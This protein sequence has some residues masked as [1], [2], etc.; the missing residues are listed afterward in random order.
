MTSWTIVVPIKGLARAKTR[1]W[2]LGTPTR[3]TL[4]R[5]FARDTLAAALAAETVGRVIAVG[6]AE[7]L[8]DLDSRV[9]IVRESESGLDAAIALGVTH[10]RT[11]SLEPVAVMLGDLPALEAPHLMSALRSAEE[12]P[13]AFVADVHGTGTTLVTANAGQRFEHCFGPYS[14]RRH[15]AARFADLVATSPASIRPELRTDA[16]TL[17]DLGVAMRMGVGLHTAAAV[18]SWGRDLERRM[19][20]AGGIDPRCA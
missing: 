12:Y 2:P 11:L 16:D 13:R 19:I 5:A 20:V 15:R 8:T 10:A 17:R 9:E 1:L 4:A 6:R 14:A 7:E 18:A 3:E